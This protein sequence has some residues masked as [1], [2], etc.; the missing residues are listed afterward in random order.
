[1]PS[2]KALMKLVGHACSLTLAVACLALQASA[3]ERA[4][5]LPDTIKAKGQLTVGVNGIFAP[6]EFKNPG[7]EDLIGVDVEV[8]QALGKAL[9]VK[10]VFDDQRFDQLLLSVTTGRVDFVISALSDTALRRKTYDFIDYFVSGTQAYT[11]KTFSRE[12]KKLDDLSGKTIAVSGATDY[13]RTMEKWS[14]ENLEAKGKPGFTLLPVDSEATARL[15]MVQGRAQFSAISPE[16]LGWLSKQN[17]GQ[18]VP[19]GP[20]LGPDPYGMCFK[21]GNTELRDAVFEAFARIIK[22]G[23][24]EKIVA[25]WE[26]SQSAVPEPL[27]NGEKKQ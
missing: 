1:M 5:K 27:L 20:V 23:T 13:W 26:V 7:S 10:V 2:S 15:Q 6:M 22:D 11:T 17:Q 3:A 8:A 24:Y 19:V 4:I 12:F 25:K 18:F 16:V 14:R 21:K 9:G